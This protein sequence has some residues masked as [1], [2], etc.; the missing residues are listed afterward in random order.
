MDILQMAG[1]AAM[2]IGGLIALIGWI[3]LIVLGFKTGGALWGVLN[4]F[5]QPITGII[6]CVMHKTGWIALAM[7]ILGNIVAIIGMIPIL[8][9]NMNNL[10]PM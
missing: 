10:Q 1:L 4:I 9:S 5:F 6:F 8:M 7:L 3:W 2:L